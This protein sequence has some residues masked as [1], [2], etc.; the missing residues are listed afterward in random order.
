MSLIIVL[1]YL[2]FPAALGPGLYSASNRNEFQKQK[3]NVP[4]PSAAGKI[5]STEKNSFT[6][7]GHEPA[8]FRLAAQCLNHYTTACPSKRMYLVQN[9]H[10]TTKL[11]WSRSCHEYVWGSGDLAPTILN[12]GSWREDRFAP[13]GGK[14]SLV[15]TGWDKQ[16]LQQLRMLSYQGLEPYSTVV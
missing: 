11:N 7:S 10:I 1:I 16:I 2:I 9:Y 4:G 6:S 14:E 13:R 3:N 8:T 15:S 12:L 5:R